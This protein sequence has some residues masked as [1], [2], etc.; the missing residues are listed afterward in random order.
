M[1]DS[2]AAV[3]VAFV[4]V[5]G[6]TG[7]AA[8]DWR[9]ISSTRQQTGEDLL[10]VSLQY[11][12]GRL[13]IAPAPSANTLYRTSLRY[14][15]DVF[16]PV[17][18]YNPGRLKV[19]VEGGNIKGRNLKSGH[20]E[21]GLTR[22]VPL[23][24]DL[25]FGATEAMIELGGLRIRSAEIS[26]GASKTTLKFSSPNP[27]PCERLELEVGAAQFEAI[28]IGNL[29]P[30]RLEVKC[31]V[32][33]VTLDFG[34]DLRTNMRA[35]IDMGLGSLILRV[36]RGLGV[37]VRKDGIL[38][39]FDSQGLIKRGD[40]YYSENWDKATHHLTINIDAA[41][42]SIRMAWIEPANGN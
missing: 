34:G 17:V 12:A 11:G 13:E 22:D 8:Q 37:S 7:L 40:V 23:E 33:E 16:K 24:L 25:Q 14:D 26:T 20:L 35:D 36:P 29:N 39:G 5:A 18:S 2:L 6:P 3:L 32:G 10:R 28:G 31:G 41:L 9:T 42:G 30:E 19:G 21:L 15:A 4:A 1:S 38:A 27:E